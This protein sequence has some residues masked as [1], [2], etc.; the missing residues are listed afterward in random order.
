[1]KQNHAISLQE[2]DGGG[3]DIG[4]AELL[5]ELELDLRDSELWLRDLGRSAAMAA[6]SEMATGQ[7][8]S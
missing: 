7:N 4:G 2:C 8:H 1:M 5:R 6:N 3:A